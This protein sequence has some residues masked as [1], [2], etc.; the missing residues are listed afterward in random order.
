MS[1]VKTINRDAESAEVGA[2]RPRRDTRSALVMIAPAIIGLVA[3]VIVPFIAAGYLSLFNVR[4]NSSRP[5][6]WFGLEQYHRILTDPTFYRGLLNNFIFAAVVVPVQ[7]LL[8]LGLA[9]LLNQSLRFMSVFRTFFFMPVVFPMALVAVIWKLIFS[10]DDLGMLNA[11]LHAISF[12]H[13]PP[14][15]WLGSTTTALLSIIILSIWQGVGFQMIIILAGL[16][17]ISKSLYEAAQIDTANRWQQFLNIT[18]PG[19]RNTL[20]FVVMVTTIFA[21][22]L[23]DQVYILT[24]GGPQN[25]TTTVMYQAVTSAFTENNVG[26][27]A[28][29]TVVFFVIVLTI[30]VVQRRL[31]R[32]DREVA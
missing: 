8:A 13:I 22:R 16:Q 19:L 23:F 29:I 15:D 9:L 6:V 18:V 1:T 31:L 5:P 14:I 30:T 21:F 10:R 28:A 11:F 26:R 3:F 24:Q 17:G 20:I 12:G 4:A 7:T 25:A 2:G 27:G 32:E